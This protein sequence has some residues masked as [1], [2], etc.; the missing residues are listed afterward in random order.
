MHAYVW[1][2]TTRQ[3]NA[4]CFDWLL[5]SRLLNF[6]LRIKRFIVTGLNH[7]VRK[8]EAGYMCGTFKEDS[9]FWLEKDFKLLVVQSEQWCSVWING[10]KVMGEELA[11]RFR[12]NKNRN[13][14]DKVAVAQLSLKRAIRQSHSYPYLFT[15]FSQ[16]HMYFTF[17]LS[18]SNLCPSRYYSSFITTTV[19]KSII[20]SVKKC[21]IMTGSVWFIHLS[22]CS[23]GRVRWS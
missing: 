22:L 14:C 1:E 2:G 19:I 21:K 15:F 4:Q 10:N 11:S 5:A 16:F 20:P 18:P 9:C 23:I 6:S 12:W 13:D 3:Y 17:W 7:V 8:H